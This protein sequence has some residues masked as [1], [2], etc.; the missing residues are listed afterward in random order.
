MGDTTAWMLTGKTRKE[1]MIRTLAMIRENH[2]SVEKFVIDYC[3]LT[4][5]DIEQIRRNLI[6][7]DEMPLDWQTHAKLT[8]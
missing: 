4:P 8:Q 5:A 2:G 3:G 6:V 1:N 7:D